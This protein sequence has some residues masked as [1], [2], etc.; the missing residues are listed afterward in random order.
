MSPISRGPVP[1]LASSRHVNKVSIYL[2]PRFHVGMHWRN[3]KRKS[4][5]PCSKLILLLI[6]LTLSH[7]FRVRLY[8]TLLWKAQSSLCH[9]ETAQRN[10]TSYLGF[11]LLQSFRFDLRRGT[12]SRWPA[13]Y[14]YIL[15]WKRTSSRPSQYTGIRSLARRHVWAPL[16]IVG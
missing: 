16:F 7:D 4:V 9:H 10:S 12:G 14:I 8:L 11:S 6:S 15:R 13:T 5:S 3:F 2:I 1:R